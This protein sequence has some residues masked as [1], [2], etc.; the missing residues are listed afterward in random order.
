[1]T[2]IADGR[3]GSADLVAYFF[4]RAWSLLNDRGGFG[5]LAVNTIAEG[6]TRQVGLEAMVRA[7]ATIHAAYPNEPWPGSA[8]V[9][10]SRVHARRG[11]WN[12][13]R[14]ILGRSVPFISAYLSD[15]E[16]WSPKRLE[17]SKH[18]AFQGSV[19]VGMGF[20]LEPDE[21]KRMLDADDKNA[22]VVLPYLNG[23]DLNSEPD[24]RASR[25][26][27]NFWDWPQDRARL[28]KLPWRRVE[29]RVKAE[30]ERNKRK[31]YRDYWWQFAE[32][33]PGL[34][35]AIGRGHPFE[36][37][38]EGW[39]SDMRPLDQVLISA[40]VGKYFGPS[41]VPNDSVFSHAC[42][43]F[44]VSPPF[45][46]ATLLNSSPGQAWVWQQSSRH[47]TRLRF[48]PSDAIETLPFPN[49]LTTLAQ[50]GEVYLRRRREV[51]RDDSIGLTKLYNRFHDTDDLDS[52][53]VR[54]REMH[55]EI[56][57]AVM[58]V[59]GWEDLDLGHGYHEQS[60]LTENDRVRFTISDVARAEILRRFAEL[61]RQRYE[62]EQ[63]GAPAAKPRASKGRAKPVPASQGVFDLVAPEAEPKASKSKVAAHTKK[64][65]KRDSP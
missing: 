30:R 55:R 17:F 3:R 29:E 31:V 42:A 6:D 9:V 5:L 22:N 58:R 21:A 18:T 15:Q 1:V 49:Q 2:H 4:L 38:P 8:A 47:E 40:F 24:Q 13:E 26:V 7:G 33:C 59:Y 57:A 48:A 12:G 37:H 32:K 14:S 61:N 16:E 10:T 52:R 23:E 64:A 45:A 19:V 50:L 62:E 28:Y 63:T 36:Q 25:W 51:M 54:M 35:H 65:T 34:Y 60:S 43:V 41:V 27:I 20:V 11:E 44:S 56:D 46:L 39:L 53:I